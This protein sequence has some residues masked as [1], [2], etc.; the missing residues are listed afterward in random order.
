MST[1]FLFFVKKFLLFIK[2]GAANAAPGKLFLAEGHTVG[3]L[4][5]CRVR[6]V[7]ADH[8]LVQRTVVGTV[9]VMGTL[10]HSTFDAL[11]RIAVHCIFLLFIG[12]GTVCP[13]III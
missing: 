5:H 9:A 3:T 8:D 4:V 2:Y 12:I 6:L 7:S 11:I 1:V 10:G 13:E